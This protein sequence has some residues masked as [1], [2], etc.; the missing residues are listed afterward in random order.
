MQQPTSNADCARPS[1]TFATDYLLDPVQAF[2]AASFLAADPHRKLI[3]TMMCLVA[4]ARHRQ[5]RVAAHVR[6]AVGLPRM[7]RCREDNAWKDSEF[8]AIFAPTQE[9]LHFPWWLVQS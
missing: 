4:C 9:R 2:L 3:R 6:L 8:M 1:G 5:V 7:N